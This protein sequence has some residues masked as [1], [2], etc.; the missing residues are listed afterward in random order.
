[1][2]VGARTRWMWP[3]KSHDENPL[4]FVRCGLAARGWS[5]N[6]RARIAPVFEESE[7][8]KVAHIRRVSTWKSSNLNFALLGE[9]VTGLSPVRQLRPPA[10]H[11]CCGEGRRSACAGPPR[12][13]REVC[14]SVPTSEWI[15]DGSPAITHRIFACASCPA[16]VVNV[17]HPPSPSRAERLHRG[18]HP[19]S[20]IRL[21]P[22][23]A[24]AAARGGRSHADQKFSF[25]ANCML[26]L[27]AIVVVIRPAFGFPMLA[28]GKPKAG[29][30]NRLNASHRN[31]RFDR[32]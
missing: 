11:A 7:R 16:A 20:A 28:L 23:A 32:P 30:L 26:R 21:N 22:P 3:A 27:S 25:S 31:S 6:Q 17:N 10:S 12:G 18:G 8:R 13:C 24:V 1:M 2:K 29:W 15:D 19:T 9:V 14:R 4:A 5:R